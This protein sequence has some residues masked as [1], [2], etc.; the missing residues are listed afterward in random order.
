MN[1]TKYKFKR[2]FCIK[3]P[4]INAGFKCFLYKYRSDPDL[5]LKYILLCTLNQKYFMNCA[6]YLNGQASSR[7]Y[8]LSNYSLHTV[9]ENIIATIKIRKYFW[10]LPFKII[11]FSNIAIAI[12]D[13][14][15]VDWFL[16]FFLYCFQYSYRSS[17]YCYK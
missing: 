12:L 9:G 7:R 4:D 13:F 2:Q 8:A 1:S 10:Y 17:N 3:N 16:A 6:L 5:S 15:F 11:H 14:F